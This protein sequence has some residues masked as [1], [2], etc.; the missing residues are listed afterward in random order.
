M[1]RKHIASFAIAATALALSI[2][3][4][5]A[6]QGCGPGGWRNAWGQCRYAAPVIYT[7]PPAPVS[8]YACPPG[9]WLGPWGHCRDTPYHGRLPN[10]MYQ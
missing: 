8:T 5:E 3:T 1:N 9:Y 4:A 2:G 10:G 6:A 7:P